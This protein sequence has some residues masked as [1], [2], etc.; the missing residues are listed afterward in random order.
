MK[1]TVERR[2]R[3]DK[4][5]ALQLQDVSRS[6]IARIIESGGVVV[7][8]KES[9]PS[10][11]LK[12]GQIIELSEVL[13]S[14]PH[15]LEPAEIPIPVLY[16]DDYV[17]VVNKPRGLATHPAKTLKEPTLVNALLG[18]GGNLSTGSASF[19]PG[20]VHRLDKETTGLLVV[21]KTDAAHVHLSRQIQE[22]TAIRIY[23][24]VLIGE[25]V[26]KKIE[27]NAPI[28]RDPRNRLKMAVVDHGK[29]A[30]THLENLKVFKLP[31]VGTMTLVKLR[32]GTGRTHQIRVH[33]Q[34]IGHPVL[35]DNLYSAK[36]YHHFPMQLHAYQLDFTHPVTGERFSFNCD[37]PAD[38]LAP[39]FPK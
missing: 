6:K 12:L 32:L 4:F 38:F 10:L 9:K 11:M 17:M 7:D 31:H 29:P 28:G 13:E 20:I 30:S 18:L 1:W 34:A 3:L 26:H 21:A 35:G 36:E 8:G 22:K 14:E 16:E 5:L 39:D 37:P 25:V 2:S 27:I 19:R 23:Q 33:V 24:A 15:L